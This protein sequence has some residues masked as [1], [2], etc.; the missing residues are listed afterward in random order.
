MGRLLFQILLRG[1][2][3]GPQ[4][5]RSRSWLRGQDVFGLGQI[6]G[7]LSEI[8]LHHQGVVVGGSGPVSHQICPRPGQHR[9]PTGQ[10]VTIGFERGLGVRSCGGAGDDGRQFSF[11]TL[12]I[13]EGFEQLLER[14]ITIP[15]L[16]GLRF[17]PPQQAS[18][19]VG[20]EVAALCVGQPDRR[21]AVFASAC[22]INPVHHARQI[23]FQH[24]VA[25]GHIR[26][27]RRQK[28]GHAVGGNG[29]DTAGLQL[30]LDF[31]QPFERG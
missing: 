25:P 13:I 21:P 28:P 7:P 24:P 12:K 22:G 20:Q 16:G 19:S 29:A 14:L 17:D 31:K 5:P 9:S 30:R 10:L 27:Q 18:I 26:H 23:G 4:A 2:Q 15:H 6:T 1:I 11:L 3:H 8:F